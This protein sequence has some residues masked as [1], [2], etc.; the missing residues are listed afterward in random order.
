MFSL[1]KIDFPVKQLLDRGVEFVTLINEHGRMEESACKN[2]IPLT[3]DKK[4]IFWME[5]KLQ[6]SM[7]TDFDEFLGIVDYTVTRRGSLK[8]LSIPFGS[9]II[10]AVLDK[11]KNHHNFVRKIASFAKHGRII[12][13]KT[14]EKE[15]LNN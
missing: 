1:Q 5:L 11:K 9:K 6:N 15:V 12:R 4:E 8:F 2:D 7:Q 3:L 10:F 14:L 13:K